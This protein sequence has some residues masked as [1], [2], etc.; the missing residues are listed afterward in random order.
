MTRERRAG[1]ALAMGLFWS[2]FLCG[3]GRGAQPRL[4]KLHIESQPLNGALL[5]FARLT[6]VQILFFS[7]LAEGLHAPQLDGTYTIAT[8]MTV[9]LSESN[10]TFRM[11]NPR[12]LEI[13]PVEPTP[14]DRD[15]AG[16]FGKATPSTAPDRGGSRCS[17]QKE[18][19]CM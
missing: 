12:T 9:L 19:T 13:V 14:T 18:F 10:L 7:Y 4:Y 1:L 5:E 15:P 2:C 3:D 16:L 8:A 11:I 6:G 17:A